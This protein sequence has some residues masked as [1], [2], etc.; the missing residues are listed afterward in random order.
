MN[1]VLVHPEIPPNTGNIGRLC[2]A[3][4]ATL[5]LIRPLGFHIDDRSLKRAGLDYWDKLDL[6]VWDDLEA[7]L[8]SVPPERLVLTGSKRGDAYHRIRFR[9]D[10]HILFGPETTG[11]PPEL[12]ARFPL[13]VAR[14]PID[15]S[16]VR[17]LNLSTSAGIVVYEALR[18]TGALPGEQT[19]PTPEAG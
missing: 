17:S 2:C 16:K 9:P 13:R 5:H 15:L 14:I 12:F 10:D 6:V 19:L 8:S 4:G 11:L 18:Q 1:V 7:Y 3:V